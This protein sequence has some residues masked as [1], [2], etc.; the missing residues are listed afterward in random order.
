ME[1]LN[2]LNESNNKQSIFIIATNEEAILKALVMAESIRNAH[3][4]LDVITNTAGGGFKSQFK[5]ADKSGARLALILGEDEI[6]REY[7]SIKDLRTE[8]E[9]V[10]IPMS[11]IN[12]FLQDYLA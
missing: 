2:L 4:S 5:K 8:I 6:A 9:Q 11:K 1:T 7:V 10:S 3:P 12:E